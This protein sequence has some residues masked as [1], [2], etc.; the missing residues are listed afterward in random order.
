MNYRRESLTLRERR[1]RAVEQARRELAEL[2]EA[3]DAEIRR[4]YAAGMPRS[5]I[6]AELSCDRAAVY[7]L[8]DPALHQKNSVLRLDR[9]HR[10]RAVA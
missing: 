10:L 6:A 4:L 5:L 1:D 8:L 3:R 7:E 9:Y 2:R